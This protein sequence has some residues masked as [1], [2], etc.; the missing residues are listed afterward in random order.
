MEAQESLALDRPKPSPFTRLLNT[1][2]GA[3]SEFR[4]YYAALFLVLLVCLTPIW[5]VSYP[6]LTDYPNHLV[7]DYILAHYHENPLWQQ[8]YAVDLTPLPNLAIEFFVVPLQKFLP[9]IVCGKLFLSIT[10]ALYVL[11]CSELGKVITGKPNWLALVCALTFYNTELLKGLVNFTFG[12]AVFFCVFAFWLRIRDR[13]SSM[14]FLLCSLLSMVAFLSHLSSAVLLGVA[15]STVAFLEFVKHRK[16]LK[17]IFELAWLGFPVLLSVAFLHGSGKVG[18]IVWS[19]GWKAKL[20]Q[21]LSPVRSYNLSLV[22]AVAVTLLLCLFVMVKGST[23]HRMWVVGAVFFLL[24]M[25]SPNE[26]FTATNVGERYVI[27]AYLLSL[28]SIEPRW[29]RGQ[30]WALGLAL[31][32]VTA[33][34][35][36]ITVNWFSI[37]R[38]TKQVIAMG[39]L[40]PERASVFVLP[41]WGPGSA[42]T[43]THSALPEDRFLNMAQFWTLSRGA[44][45]SNLFALPGQQPLIFRQIACHGPY[46]PE[47]EWLGCLGSFDFVWTIDPASVYRQALEGIATPEATVGEATLWRV[48]RTHAVEGQSP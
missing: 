41:T 14:Y 19:F 33:S 3:I 22:A 6:G 35:G 29:A 17:L 26:L 13:M 12:I 34:I 42:R 47:S 8:R 27:P 46:P 1:R 44:D 10:A 43:M 39:E 37:S 32:A 11:G 5:I 20:I 38:E 15:C 16:P 31:I 36:N 48:N 9:L 28:L 23:V 2:I 4:T 45:V 30:K 25:V 18:P 21:L 7:R 40:L 24:F